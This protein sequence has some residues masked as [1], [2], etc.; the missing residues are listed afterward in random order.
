M[1]IAEPDFPARID[2][3]GAVARQPTGF[4]DASGDGTISGEYSTLAAGLGISP[5]LA[6]PEGDLCRAPHRGTCSRASS[7]SRTPSAPARPPGVATCST[8]HPV[9]R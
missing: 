5:R 7:R 8:G 6:G 9:T 4:G 1:R 3:P 2:V